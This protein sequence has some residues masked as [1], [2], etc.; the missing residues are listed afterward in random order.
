M[1]L[2][3]AIFQRN[4]CHLH[5]KYVS[6]NNFPK[7]TNFMW[8]KRLPLIIIVKYMHYNC[9]GV[10]GITVFYLTWRRG[11]RDIFGLPKAQFFF[12]YIV[13]TP[14]NLERE[15]VLLIL[16]FC[17]EMM[18]WAALM[19]NIS[20]SFLAFK[21]TTRWVYTVSLFFELWKNIMV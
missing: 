11:E 12:G 2:C 9:M 4:L 13:N 1:Y 7:D 16:L 6:P 20:I 17:F 21:L 5:S 10:L 19:V 18:I 8:R 15:F 3:V 14:N